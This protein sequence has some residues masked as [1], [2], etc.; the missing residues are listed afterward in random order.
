M[1]AC[2]AGAA[3]TALVCR[4]RRRQ[5]PR[6]SY[7]QYR[8]VPG[9]AKGRCTESTEKKPK[10][11]KVPGVC[12]ALLGLLQARRSLAMV[13]AGISLSSMQRNASSL[14]LGDVRDSDRQQGRG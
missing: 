7:G 2:G 5:I 11:Q 9:S 6:C 14:Q 4:V 3:R 13:R 10:S 12:A 8:F 1:P